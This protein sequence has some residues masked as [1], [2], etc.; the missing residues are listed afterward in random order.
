M[1]DQKN[2]NKTWKVEFEK[3]FFC[4]KYQYTSQFCC[5]VRKGIVIYFMDNI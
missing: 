5:T 1:K 2:L 3:L 4:H